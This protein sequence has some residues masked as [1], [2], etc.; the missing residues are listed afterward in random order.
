MVRGVPVQPHGCGA[1]KDEV[2]IEVR[3]ILY[4][5]GAH[6]YILV[7]GQCWSVLGGRANMDREDKGW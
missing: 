3:P 6:L 2:Y 5:Y 1:S 4:V 7:G